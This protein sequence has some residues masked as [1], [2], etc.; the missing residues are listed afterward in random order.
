VSEVAHI[1]GV[2]H[3]FP[4][5]GIPF[6]PVHVQNVQD[7]GDGRTIRPGAAAILAYFFPGPPQHIGP[8]DAVIERMEPTV[9]AAFGRQGE[10]ALEVLCFV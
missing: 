5:R 2:A 10:L 9:P 3:Q 7:V 6:R 1:I 8:E 4:Q